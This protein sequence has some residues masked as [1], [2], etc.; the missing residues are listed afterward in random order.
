M[1]A[2]Q[3]FD[4]VAAHLIKQNEPSR[5]VDQCRYRCLYRG[6]NGKSCAVGCLIKDEYYSAALEGKGIRRPAVQEAVKMSL[7]MTTRDFFNVERLLSELQR[8][9][10]IAVFGCNDYASYWPKSLQKV[11]TE[12]GLTFTNP[13]N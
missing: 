10:D 12:F 7:D 9:H 2:Q 4:K 8:V 3:I 6:P 13:T 5:G 11:A 1:N